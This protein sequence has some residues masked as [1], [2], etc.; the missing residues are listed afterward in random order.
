[1][2][3]PGNAAR[4]FG[5][6]ARLVHCRTRAF[7]ERSARF[8]GCA[9]IGRRTA[10]RDPGACRGRLLL[11]PSRR[12]NVRRQPCCV[13]DDQPALVSQRATRRTLSYRELLNSGTRGPMTAWAVAWGR[14]RVAGF[15]PNLLGSGPRCSPRGECG[16]TWPSCSPD[17]GGARRASIA[18]GRFN[19]GAVTA[20]ATSTPQ[21]SIRLQPM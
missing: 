14:Y 4:E 11:S 10:H 3:A 12:L 16:A 15:L 21:R 2:R 1:M 20:D 6:L 18:S 13:H 19:Q 17:F 8:A 5:D 9:R 7:L